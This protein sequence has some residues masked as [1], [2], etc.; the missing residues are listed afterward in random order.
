MKQRFL[1]L[2]LIIP[3]LIG[4]API[5]PAT[6]LAGTENTPVS[7]GTKGFPVTVTSCGVET[8]Y[9]AP[10]TRAVAM[11]QAATEFMLALGLE[12]QM[13]GTAY[14][15]DEAVLP[16]WQ[17]AYES[18][19][20]LAEEYPSQEVLLAVEPDF[21]FA[22]Y[23]SAFGDEAAGSRAQLAELGIHSYL[24]VTSCEEDS[25]RP[26]KI[27]FDILFAEI[28][29]IGQI[30]GVSERA[31][32]LVAKM[33]ADL[34]NVRTTIGD[35]SEAPTI[36]WFDSGDDAPFTGACCGG[37][38]MLME[39]VGAEN[40]FADLPGSWGDV[41][42]EEVIGRN[43]G[44]IVLADANWSTA[45]EKIDLLN[46]NP[47]FASI[48]AVQQQRFVPIPFGATTYGVR[49]IEGALALAFG[50]YPDKFE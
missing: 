9:E 1:A 29:T 14:L 22:A 33:Q 12:D 3:L 35:V 26:A 38:A 39:A 44:V 32:A 6:P 13:V 18:V 28:R 4:C 40:L 16:E 2:F 30:F 34:E 10:P 43:P 31:E 5:A 24:L 15:D 21:V 42:W 27:T 7:T 19:P 45:Q 8:T 48:E 17:A 50:L 36:F 46:D 25:L 41:T 23:R 37:P 49:N 11:N 20:V 47:A